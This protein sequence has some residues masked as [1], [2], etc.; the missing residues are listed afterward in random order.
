MWQGGGD[1]SYVCF[2]ENGSI[3]FTGGIL[4][5]GVLTKQN[6]RSHF[7]LFTPEF[8]VKSRWARLLIRTSVSCEPHPTHCTTIDGINADLH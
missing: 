6:V 2:K 5:G 3:A 8:G 7:C 4:N 1:T